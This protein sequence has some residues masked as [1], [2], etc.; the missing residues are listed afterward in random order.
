MLCRFLT[1]GSFSPA[2]SS[3]RARALLRIGS[4]ELKHNE[5]QFKYARLCSTD[6]FW[7]QDLKKHL[8]WL[9]KAAANPYPKPN[10]EAM[11][12]LA[13][14]LVTG[15]GGAVE[16]DLDRAEELI[17]AATTLEPP[18]FGN[19]QA[20]QTSELIKKMRK[21]PSY[22]DRVVWEGLRKCGYCGKSDG[23][24]KSCSKCRLASYCSKECQTAAWP[25]HK[26]ECRTAPKE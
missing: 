24:L 20:M 8:K 10:A 15:L 21:D 18:S 12:M 7:P 17:K 14:A 5:L 23:T 13:H 19:T 22:V 25:E 2:V 9:E 1:D 11:N 3:S 6:I 26:K 4:I 16:V